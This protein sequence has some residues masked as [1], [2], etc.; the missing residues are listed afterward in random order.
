MLALE[1]AISRDQKGNISVAF[2]R[3]GV[4]THGEVNEARDVQDGTNVV[5]L[6]ADTDIEFGFTW[7][8]LEDVASPT[9]TAE[10]DFGPLGVDVSRPEGGTAD[11]VLNRVPGSGASI[12]FGPGFGAQLT[13]SEGQIQRPPV[14]T[15]PARFSEV[16]SR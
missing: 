3:L 4:V 2:G 12:S 6:S 11:S 8:R 7:G 13:R 9:E 16:Y 10:A 15:K 1:T 5:G 14:P